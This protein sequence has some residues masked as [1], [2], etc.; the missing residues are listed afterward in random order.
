MAGVRRFEDLHAWK[1]ATQV[2]DAVYELTRSGPV[3]ADREFRNQIRNSGSSAP[4]N[5]AEGWGR[6]NPKD[7]ANFLRI[8][9]GSLNETKNH[10]L[11]GRRLNYF[12]ESDFDRVH[13]LT[14]RALGATSALRRY[15]L[16]CGGKL[17]WEP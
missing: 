10:L 11:K 17:P 7:F 13:I 8:A 2:E 12:S 9:R 14:C 16:A 5:I 15:L 1:L 4:S 3:M 6:L